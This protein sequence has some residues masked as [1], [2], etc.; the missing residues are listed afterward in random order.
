[1]AWRGG[2]A[3]QARGGG[4]LAPAHHETGRNPQRATPI[5]PLYRLPSEK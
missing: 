2:K 4:G 1:V 5:D 3:R